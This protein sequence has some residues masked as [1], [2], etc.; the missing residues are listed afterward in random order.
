M[1]E[2]LMTTSFSENLSGEAIRAKVRQFYD[3]GSPLYFEVYGENIHDGY[4]LT[5]KESRQEAQENLTRLI[6]EKARIK[7]GDR[8]LDVGCGVGGSSLWMS[9]N[10]S[11]STVGIT[12]SPAQLE[13]ARRLAQERNADSSFYLMNA[14]Q[15]QF[16][17]TFDVIWAVACSTH[18]QNQEQFVKSSGL[19]LRAGGRFVIFDWMS[20]ENVTDVKN[21]RYLKPVNEGMLLASL[22][23]TNNYLD[24]FIQNGYRIT[25]SE[26]VTDRTA[27]T[28]DDA[29]SVIRDP[30]IL[31]Y[32][33]RINK[34]EIAQILHFFKSV[35]A[36]KLAMK[37]GKMKAA[38]V[39]AEKM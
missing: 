37:K 19:Y 1:Q 21:D 35:R 38:I 32:A 23:S 26:D 12:I 3:L 29:L 16:D 15:M 2:G 27:K 28:W 6:A 9:S 31:K 39:V 4:Y 18:F 34:N 10:L 22:C 33:T 20:N 5:G 30:S 25:Y 24:W 14:E 8:V 13:I 36:M 7:K 17:E 11:A